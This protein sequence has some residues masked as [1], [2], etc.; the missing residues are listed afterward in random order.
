MMGGS[1]KQRVLKLLAL[2]SSDPIKA[3]ASYEFGELLGYT[4]GYILPLRLSY[5]VNCVRGALRS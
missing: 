3:T 5:I 2:P 4:I 1:C